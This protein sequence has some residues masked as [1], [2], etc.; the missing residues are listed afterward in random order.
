MS[1][2]VIESLLGLCIQLGVYFK[3][4]PFYDIGVMSPFMPDIEWRKHQSPGTWDRLLQRVGFLRAKVQW[5]P[6][7]TLGSFGRFVLDNRVAVRLAA[8]KPLT[9][10]HE[11]ELWSCV[12]AGPHARTQVTPRPDGSPPATVAKR[13][14]AIASPLCALYY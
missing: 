3:S 12:F 13:E 11:R 5:S 8:R 2:D 14:V 6:P 9:L 7:N 1:A 4:N 10:F